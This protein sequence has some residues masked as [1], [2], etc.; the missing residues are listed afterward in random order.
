MNLELDGDKVWNM[1]SI[2]EHPELTMINIWASNLSIEWTDTL[3][4]QMGDVTISL[5]GEWDRSRFPLS[6]E[7][8]AKID[9]FSNWKK[10]ER[11]IPNQ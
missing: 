10:E 8:M 11:E 2:P 9:S 5:T 7:Q 1:R 3:T 6:D 4:T